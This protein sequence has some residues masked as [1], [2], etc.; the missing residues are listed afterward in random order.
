MDKF[1]IF[2]WLQYWRGEDEICGETAAYGYAYQG[3]GYK[4]REGTESENYFKY[5]EERIR[6]IWKCY[7]RGTWRWK[8]ARSFGFVD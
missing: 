5:W 2:D 1:F 6:E 8:V 4:I 7:G 3:E